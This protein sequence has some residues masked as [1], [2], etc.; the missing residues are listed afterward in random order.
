[1]KRRLI[2]SLAIALMLVATLSLPAVAA[3]E[4]PVT[5]SVT[6]GEF[7]SITLAGSIGFGSVTPPANDRGTTGQIDGSPAI[8][9][10][11]AGETNVNVDIGIKGVLATG[12]LLL[13]N[14]KYSKNFTD[15]TKTSIPEAYGATAVYPNAV[16]GSSNPFY[17]WITVPA[18]TASGTHTITVSYKAVKTGTP[19]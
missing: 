3:T 7:I 11:V 5:A 17:H 13:P 10:N 16:P 18:G 14:W 12:S 1:M 4:V 9:V 8:S 6:V 19:L 2:A 15:V